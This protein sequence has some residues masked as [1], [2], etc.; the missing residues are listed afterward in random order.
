M[1]KALSKAKRD[2]RNS[3]ADLI[4]AA[5]DILANRVEYLDESAEQAAR[6]LLES[7][8]AVFRLHRAKGVNRLSPDCP[9]CVGDGVTRRMT[10][11]R[12]L[13][14]SIGGVGHCYP[15]WRCNR[16]RCRFLEHGGE[17]ELEHFPERG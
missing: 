3:L 4:E 13:R 14:Y 6:E 11:F 16:C 15:R 17:L 10:S 12:P 9:E 7:L 8:E 1:S 5:E 2:A